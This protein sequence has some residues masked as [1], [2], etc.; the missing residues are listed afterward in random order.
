MSKSEQVAELSKKEFQKKV[1]AIRYELVQLQQ[2][3][4][5][6]SFPVI[7]LFEGIDG[8]GKHETSDDLNEWMDPR[9]LKTR[10]YDQPK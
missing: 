2:K 9:W 5:K 7:I 8:A 10:A 4:R 6:A 1:N 3:V